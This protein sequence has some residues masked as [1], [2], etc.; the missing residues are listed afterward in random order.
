[1][2][3]FENSTSTAERFVFNFYYR[4]Q[5]WRFFKTPI[6][7]KNDVFLI[8]TIE[9]KF[10]DFSKLHFNARTICLQ[11][12]VT[13]GDLEILEN[14]TSAAERFVFNFSNPIQIW[15]FFKIPVLRKNDVFLIST[16]E[17]KNLE[18][19]QNSTSTEERCVYNF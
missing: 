6:P 4:V 3:I 7:S 19:F 9:S 11:F 13:S 12:S 17:C 15:R 1:L 8:S 14:S 18:I 2:E 10:G 5:I 16:V